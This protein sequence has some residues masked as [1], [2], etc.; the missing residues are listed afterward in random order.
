MLKLPKLS[1]VFYQAMRQIYKL[2]LL[3]FY[4]VI[5][6]GYSTRSLLPSHLKTIAVKTVENSS[7]Q[8][9][10]AEEL[11]F[12]LPKAF[13]IDRSLRVT[14]IEQAHL[15]LSATITSYS[16]TAA[17]YNSNQEVSTYEITLTALV[18]VI[19]QI[20]NEPF[21]NGTVTSRV[22]YDPQRSSEEEVA[23]TAIEK[24]A[25]EIVRQVVTAW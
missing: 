14:S 18:D 9:G 22:P 24:L 19:D 21:F 1:L 2:L 7:T 5:G 13:N 23:R 8:P 6:C 16:K 10:L 15:L 11:T 3:V 17:A 12:A 25:R 20:R 4:L